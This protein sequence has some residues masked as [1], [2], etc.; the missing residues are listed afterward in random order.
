MQFTINSVWHVEQSDG[1]LQGS[2]L[3]CTSF[4]DNMCNHCDNAPE[5]YINILE[6][7]NYKIYI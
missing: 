5:A 1:T 2:L 4:D 7:F 3:Q 6:L